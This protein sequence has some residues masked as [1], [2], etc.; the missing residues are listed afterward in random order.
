MATKK[1]TLN[2]LRSLVKQIIKEE[3]SINA[4]NLKAIVDTKTGEVKSRG[5]D[6]YMV[7][8][9]MIEKKWNQYPNLEV[10]NDSDIKKTYIDS[11]GRQFRN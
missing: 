4:S 8:Y 6:D 9:L 3:T 2:E 7:D 1:I 10:V 5:L 11:S